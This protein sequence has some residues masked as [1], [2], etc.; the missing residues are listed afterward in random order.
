[1]WPPPTSNISPLYSN[2]SWHIYVTKDATK[3][4]F[5]FYN[6]SSLL[7]TVFNIDVPAT[8][9]IALTFIPYFYPSNANVFVNPIIPIL[10]V[11]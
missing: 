1:M 10:A 6:A 2:V 5:N 4:G 8:G 11:A 3:S 9:A 7:I